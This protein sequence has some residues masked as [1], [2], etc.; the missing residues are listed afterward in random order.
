MKQ[1]NNNSSNNRITVVE[2]TP[3]AATG[4]LHFI[5]RKLTQDSIVVQTNIRYSSHVGFLFIQCSITE[6]QSKIKLPNCDETMNMARRA[7]ARINLR[8]RHGGLSNHD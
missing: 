4:G 2:L 3:A 5:G 6:E 8:L 7:K 1:H